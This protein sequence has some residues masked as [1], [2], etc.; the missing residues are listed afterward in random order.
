V[1]LP[2]QKKKLEEREECEMLEVLPVF[3]VQVLT[4]TG[5]SGSNPEEACF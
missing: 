2:P 3:Q 5:N 1:P 4:Q